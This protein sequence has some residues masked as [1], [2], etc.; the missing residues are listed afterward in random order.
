METKVEK[1]ESYFLGTIGAVIGGLIVLVSV[2]FGYV[3]CEMI[4]VLAIAVL[5]AFL[6]FYGYKLLKGKMNK[7]LPTI[8]I[9][10]SILLATI[11]SFCVIPVALLVRSRLPISIGTIKN[12]YNNSNIVINILQ[13]YSILLTFT[14]LGTYIVNLIIKKKLVFRVSNINLFTSD[15][16]EKQ[17]FKEE[18]IKTIKPVFK[19]YDAMQEEKAISKDDIFADFKDKQ[20]SEYF[21]YLKSLMIIKKHKGKYYYS[22]DHESNIKM[23]YYMSRIIAGVAVAIAVA[24]AL[25]VIF[26]LSEKDTKKVYND[27]VSF[28]IDT[29][30]AIFQDYAEEYGWIYYKYINIDEEQLN[31]ENINTSEYLGLIGVSYSNEESTQYN[32]ISDIKSMLELYVST[33]LEIDS[34]DINILTTLKGYDAVEV[35]T[36]Y[37]ESIYYDFYIYKDGKIAS[38][39]ATTY[40]EDN[41]EEIEETAKDI[42]NSFEWNK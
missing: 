5:T 29:S 31:N 15:N 30:W 1:N 27:D 40:N 19:K 20:Y 36:T 18:A 28:K 2:V 14:L 25:L 37:G 13:D 22:T 4:G 23:Y 39:S 33:Q 12:L 11:V 26:G 38:I 32:S 17:E 34:Y 8:L 7:K 41:S 6:E 9:V 42:V 24:A 21:K 35:K 3:Y 10:T 16:K